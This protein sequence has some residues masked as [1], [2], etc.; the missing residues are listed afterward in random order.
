MSIRGTETDH[1]LVLVD[2][3]RMGAAS[4]GPAMC[5]D[6]PVDQ[7]DRIEIVRGPRSSLYGSEALGGVIQI[8]T[9][10]DR[11]AVTPRFSAGIGSNSLREASAGVGGGNER[12][13]FGIDAAYQQTDGINS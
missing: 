9:R 2:G 11:G 6:L 12:G 7:I 4:A 10:R 13:W 3:V 1:V 5:H 8:F